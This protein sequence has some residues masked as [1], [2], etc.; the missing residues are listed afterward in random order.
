MRKKLTSNEETLEMGYWLKFAKELHTMSDEMEK[1]LNAKQVK[2]RLE[3]LLE[4]T[5]K[6]VALKGEE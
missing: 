1:E 3:N 6:M 5:D 4:I 2:K